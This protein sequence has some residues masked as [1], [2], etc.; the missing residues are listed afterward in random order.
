MIGVPSLC[1]R[2]KSFIKFYP[3]LDADNVE[4][5]LTKRINGLIKYKQ[6]TTNGSAPEI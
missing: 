3:L 4:V 2:G 6:N 5:C 1:N